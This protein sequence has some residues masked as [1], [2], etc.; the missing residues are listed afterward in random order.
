MN[1]NT[2]TS[3]LFVCLHLSSERLL[4]C[5]VAIGAPDM[6]GLRRQFRST[7]STRTQRGPYFRGYCG[8]H[9]YQSIADCPASW[10]LKCK[11][12]GNLSSNP[13]IH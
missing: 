11:T 6:D 3:R 7:E 12:E 10:F 1:P 8:E 5:S 4:I 13:S 2:T 9:T